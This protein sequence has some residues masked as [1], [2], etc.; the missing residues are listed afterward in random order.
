MTIKIEKN[1]PIPDKFRGANN[2]YPFKD[3]K[4]GDSFFIPFAGSGYKDI[5]ILHNSINNARRLYV[6]LNKE[7][8]FV[9]SKTKDGTGLRIWRAK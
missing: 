5:S 7:K 9:S 3:M 6:S 2:K 4:V 1:I 8:E